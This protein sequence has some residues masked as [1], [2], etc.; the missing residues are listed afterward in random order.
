MKEMSDENN[1]SDDKECEQ[2]QEVNGPVEQITIEEI[3]N[4][5]DGDSTDGDITPIDDE[6]RPA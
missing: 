3:A 5:G 4:K 2:E 1:A 6:D